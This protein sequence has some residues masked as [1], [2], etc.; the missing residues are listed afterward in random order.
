MMVRVLEFGN[1]AFLSSVHDF[2]VSNL[3]ALKSKPETRPKNTLVL[4]CEAKAY[5]K[6]WSLGCRVL[7]SGCLS[8]D[9]KQESLGSRR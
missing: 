3:A 5:Y 4:N 7:A 1:N 9:R 8:T 2:A 6:P